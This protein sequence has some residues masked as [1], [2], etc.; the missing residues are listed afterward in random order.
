MKFK[1]LATDGAARLG[2]LHTAHGTV[3]TPV[4]M[5]VGTQASVKGLT[6]PQLVEEALVEH[7]VVLR[8]RNYFNRS[9]RKRNRRG[10]S[11]A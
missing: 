11:G 8:I 4:F 5:A 9:A 1:L 10:A 2:R 7:D 3:E 6:P